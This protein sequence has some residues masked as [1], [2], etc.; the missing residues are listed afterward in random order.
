MFLC[1]GAPAAR[2]DPQDGAHRGGPQLLLEG[3]ARQSQGSVVCGH[4]C[5]PERGATGK[6]VF[7]YLNQNKNIEILGVV[8]FKIFFFGNQR[9]EKKLF[10]SSKTLQIDFFYPL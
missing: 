7:K 4:R 8:I 10:F 6:D 5:C 1:G 2:P 9:G 3:R